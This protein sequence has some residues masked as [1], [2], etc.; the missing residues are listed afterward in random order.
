M[1]LYRNHCM[2][3]DA[4]LVDAGIPMP[5]LASLEGVLVLETFGK[6]GVS[7]TGIS[8]FKFAFAGDGAK[9]SFSFEIISLEPVAD[10]PFERC[11]SCLLNGSTMTVNVFLLDFLPSLLSLL[12]ALF[13]VA[14]NFGVSDDTTLVIDERR[15]PFKDSEGDDAGGTPAADPFEGTLEGVRFRPVSEPFPQSLP[16]NLSTEIP[17]RCLLDEPEP[18]DPVDPEPF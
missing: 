15:L 17:F 16:T 11:L 9:S 5:K 4:L 14:L 7:G 13:S 3:R 8:D 12:S 10:L 18:A 1:L 6:R 2:T